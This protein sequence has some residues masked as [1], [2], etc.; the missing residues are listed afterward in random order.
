LRRNEDA[1]LE[2]A[3]AAAGMLKGLMSRSR[4][5]RKLKINKRAAAKRQ[6]ETAVRIWFNR[7]DP[8]SIHTLSAA[9][10]EIL[11]ALGRQK[12]LRSLHDWIKSLP[13]PVQLRMH[14]AQNFFKHG[15]R[16]MTATLKYYPIHGEMLL[17]DAI[18]SY[19]ILFGATPSMLC[20]MFRYVTEYRRFFPSWAE[21]MDGAG[22]EAERILSPSRENFFD[23]YFPLLKR[24]R[25]GRILM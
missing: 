21:A 22:M 1:E 13:K 7:G 4:P 5:R 24:K 6:I 17:F 8:V 11:H 3:F 16:D 20:F 14:L 12:G 9:A 18:E 2:K 23:I 10:G 19:D 25:T 15:F